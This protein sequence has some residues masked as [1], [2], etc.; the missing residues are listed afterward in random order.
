MSTQAEI[1]PVIEP[2][3]TDDLAAAWD[4]HEK[5]TDD[6][7]HQENE[8]QHAEA[9]S[10]PDIV[11]SPDDSEGVPETEG[12]VEDIAAAAPSDEVESAAPDSLPPEAREVWKEA[13]KALQDAIAKREKDYE[14][15]IMKYAEHAKRAQQMDQ[16]LQPY[17]QYMQ[18]N[19]GPSQAIGTLLQAGANLQMGS[20]Q[21]KAGQIAQLI[22]QFGVDI[23]TLDNLLVGQAPAAD[24]QQDVQAMIQQAFSQRDQQAQAF[25][26]Q[27]GQ[28]AAASEVERFRADPKNE[29]YNDVWEDMTHILDLAA[30]R[31]EHITMADAYEQACRYNP[32]VFKIMNSRAS[33]KSVEKKRRAASSVHGTQSGPGGKT[34]PD[35]LRATIEQAWDASG[36]I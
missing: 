7:D 10:T 35:T 26:A 14:A 34:V 11:E 24:P 13:P 5:E 30:A 33:G 29:F 1:E 23:K 32:E 8:P 36:Q 2:S 21:Q 25:Q 12:E 17:S 19:G 22:S 9:D 27:Q 20:P 16:V 3:L 28:Q 18:M 4:E 6:V 15:G 31:N